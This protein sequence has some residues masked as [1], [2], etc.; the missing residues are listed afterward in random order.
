[1]NGSLAFVN[2][3]TYFTDR[4]ED[5]FGQLTRTGPYAGTLQAFTT[6]VRL[7]TRYSHLVPSGRTTRFWAS[8]SNRVI[9]TAKYFAAG[10]FDLNWES[11]GLA[12]LEVIPETAEREADTLTPG[13]TC[14]NYVEDLEFGHDYGVNTLIEFHEVYIPAIS[15]R[16]AVHNPNIN[17]TNYDVFSMQEMCGFETLLHGS[18]SWCDVF[19][20][21]D[22][23]HF[24]YARDLVH[25][26]RGGPGNRFGPVMGWLWLNATTELLLSPPEAGQLYF[27][28]VHDGDIGPMLAALDIFQD[29]FYD[30]KLPKGNIATDRKW[31]ASQIMPMG[32]R[33]ILERL[34]C[35][36]TASEEGIENENLTKQFIRINVNDGIIALP[37]C[38]SGPGH[39][40]P[41]AEF[42]ER[43]RLRG[44]EAGDFGTV[45]GLADG[46][47]KRISFLH[48]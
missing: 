15:E 36:S 46:H 25:Y 38:N 13:D 30:P 33:I 1:M 14:T 42:S 31:R 28:F 19:T 45:C 9:E 24:E 22:W 10:F 39:S 17:F 23:L 41:L 7:R 34:S 11:D 29:D 16:L 20:Q 47:A 5:H 48:Q 4:P 21:D 8:D 35:P 6:G 40:C 43:V 3:W 37:G 32:G 27:S 18:S 2:N 44:I 12:A 26:Y